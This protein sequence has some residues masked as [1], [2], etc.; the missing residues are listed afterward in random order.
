MFDYFRNKNKLE[1]LRDKYKGQRCFILGNGP[2]LNRH[3]LSKLY[4]EYT[5]VS[6]WFVLKK[7]YKKFKKAFLCISDAHLWNYGRNFHEKLIDH[8]I[9]NPG[10]KVFLEKNAK[11]AVKKEM[12]LKDMDIAYLKCNRKLKL[13]EGDFEPLIWKNVAWGF[14]VV[15]EFC[16]TLSYYMGFDKVYLLG[17]DCDYKLDESK[18]FKKSFCYDISEIPEDDLEHIRKQRDLHKAQEQLD[19]WILAYKKMKDVYQSEGR[20]IY[21]AGIDGKLDV[22]K[23]V[24]YNDLFERP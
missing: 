6:N 10:A 7:D 19:K 4:D 5:F 9:M 11:K 20:T 2:S 21:N 17:C 23:R 8:M 16:L 14:T 22:F 13:F 1:N 12:K 18:D 3:D 15:L 24:N